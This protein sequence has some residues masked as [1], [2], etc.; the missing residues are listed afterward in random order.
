MLRTHYTLMNMQEGA[1]CR[2]LPIQLVAY[3]FFMTLFHTGMTM[4][5]IMKLDKKRFGQLFGECCQVT[6]D[7]G[8]VPYERD[9]G[10]GFTISL[11]GGIRLVARDTENMVRRASRSWWT[12]LPDGVCLGRGSRVEGHSSWVGP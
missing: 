7:G 1:A 6:V 4:D 3:N 2:P 10:P 11:T 5:A 12:P 8:L 9:Y